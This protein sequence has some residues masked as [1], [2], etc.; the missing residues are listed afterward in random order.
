MIIC[1]CHRLSDRDI[2]RA[3][4]HGCASFD[5]LQ[6]DTRIATACGACTDCARQAFAAACSRAPQPLALSLSAPA[7]RTAAA[8]P[9]AA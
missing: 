3:V 5:D 7:R 9:V 4:Q 2:T 6:D 1:V 8:E